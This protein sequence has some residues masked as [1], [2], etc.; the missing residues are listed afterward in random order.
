MKHVCDEE[1]VEEILGFAGSWWVC[2]GSA[3][4]GTE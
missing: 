4:L 2:L 1:K 3:I